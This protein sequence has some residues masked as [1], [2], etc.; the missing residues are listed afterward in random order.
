MCI[1]KENEIQDDWKD[2]LGEYFTISFLTFQ[3]SLISSTEGNK[4]QGGYGIKSTADIASME[5]PHQLSDHP[6][7]IDAVNVNKN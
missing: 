1:Y 7:A 4:S 5:T 6:L 2:K 3:G